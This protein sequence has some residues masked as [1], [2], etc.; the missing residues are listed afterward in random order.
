MESVIQRFDLATSY[1][2][3][4]YRVSSPLSGLT[5]EFGMGSGVSPRTSHQIEIFNHNIAIVCARNVPLATAIFIRDERCDHRTTAQDNVVALISV[6]KPKKSLIFQR[7]AADRTT[8]WSREAV[9]AHCF[10][11]RVGRPEQIAKNH[12][13]LGSQ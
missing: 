3:L 6:D 13:V 5:S 12:D 2:P 4:L 7:D 1:F 11:T 8:A 9:L 10:R